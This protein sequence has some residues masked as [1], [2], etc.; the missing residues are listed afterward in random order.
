MEKILAPVDGS[1]WVEKARD[2]AEKQRR[3]EEESD[4][5][6]IEKQRLES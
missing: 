6:K 2:D 3:R 5:I 1:E 4:G